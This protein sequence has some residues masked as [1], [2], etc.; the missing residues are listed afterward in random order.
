M[1]EGTHG[2]LIE[3][4]QR[5]RSC[6]W[7]RVKKNPA[8][9]RLIAESTGNRKKNEA[10]ITSLGAL[11]KA[12]TKIRRLR[13][14]RGPHRTHKKEATQNRQK[15]KSSVQSLGALQKVKTEMSRLQDPRGPHRTHKKK[16]NKKNKTKKR[17]VSLSP[18]LPI[19]QRSLARGALERA[20]LHFYHQ[21]QPDEC[22]EHNTSPTATASSVR[23]ELNSSGRHPDLRSHMGQASCSL[24]KMRSTIWNGRSNLLQMS[25]RA[26]T[27][28]SPAA[29]ALAG[30]QGFY[31]IRRQNAVASNTVLSFG[32]F[33]APCLVT[34]KPL[35]WD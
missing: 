24:E 11:Q 35:S 21:V 32:G 7:G 27:I 23:P 20:P 25:T 6:C 13:S 5:I 17:G 8:S 18:S 4:A 14:P 3:A 12:K 16:K 34:L 19:A 31:L 33:F 29:Q 9:E 28:P 1:N 15:K 22:S 30:L 26:T 2:S 10:S